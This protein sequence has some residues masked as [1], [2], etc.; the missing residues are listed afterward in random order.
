[1]HDVVADTDLT[2]AFYSS[3]ATSNMTKWLIEE[4][5]VDFE[6]DMGIHGPDIG[7]LCISIFLDW[8]NVAVFY[9]C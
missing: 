1:L 8:F 3:C 7:S 6:T 4:S 9:F 2:F 5:L